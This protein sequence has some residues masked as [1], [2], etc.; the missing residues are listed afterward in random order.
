MKGV[1]STVNYTGGGVE[2]GRIKH[3]WQDMSLHLLLQLNFRQL[4][5]LGSLQRQPHVQC[6]VV[7]NPGLPDCSFLY[8]L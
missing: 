6:I 1:S 8:L 2:L 4:A 7:V 3:Q 5:V